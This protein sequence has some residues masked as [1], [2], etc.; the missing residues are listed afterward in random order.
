MYTIEKQGKNKMKKLDLQVGDV[1]E[2]EFGHLR[3]IVLH[4]D[5]KIGILDLDAGEVFS[6]DFES[7]EQL[8]SEYS[9][10]GGRITAVRSYDATITLELKEEL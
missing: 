1:F 10:D 9:P 8:C 6:D 5:G 3:M 2:T 4:A 7:P